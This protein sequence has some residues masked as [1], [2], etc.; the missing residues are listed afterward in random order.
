MTNLIAQ[1]GD[2][3][4]QWAL[5]P[6]GFHDV[7]PPEAEQEAAATHALTAILRQFG[8]DRVTP[9]LLEFEETLLSGVGAALTADSFR[10]MDPVS[11]RMMA[12]R[13]DMTV[14]IARLAAARL[15]QSP[16]PLRLAYAGQVL[17]VRGSQLRPERQ[18]TQVGAELI[19]ADQAAAD[20]EIAAL[21]AHALQRLGVRNLSIDLNTPGIV[22]I[23]LDHFAIDPAAHADVYLG[24]SRK[25]GDHVARVAGP[26]APVLLALMD[27]TGPAD[28]ALAALTGIDLPEEVARRVER[29]REVVTLLGASAPTVPLTVDVV[30]HRGFE[31]H[32]GVSF[33]LFSR[34]IRGELGRGGHY[35]AGAQF[36]APVPA[37]GFTVFMDSV[38]RAIPLPTPEPRVYVP[39]GTDT[40][41]GADLRSAGYRTIAGLSPETPDAAADT[42]RRL[43]CTHISVDGTACPLDTN[44]MPSED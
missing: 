34:G 24:L 42:A 21:A 23:L 37:T 31:Y 39:F 36:G 18:F 38:C 40:G 17:R 1:P 25:D 2:Q 3:R 14:Q 15:S 27:A 41:V 13:A 11:Q 29:L 26:A 43:G 28:A 8:Y 19:G 30:E 44:S 10:V 5:L 22:A 12:V 9:P 35:L 32:R 7:L 4:G 16:R 20:A 33:T 6:A